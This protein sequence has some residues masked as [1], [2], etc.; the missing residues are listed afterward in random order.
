MPAPHN[1][2]KPYKVTTAPPMLAFIVAWDPSL[3]SPEQYAR[4]VG[5]IG[6]LVRASGGLGVRRQKEELLGVVS[7]EVPV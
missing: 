4:L 6:D 5:A 1:P 2:H 3:I 7:S